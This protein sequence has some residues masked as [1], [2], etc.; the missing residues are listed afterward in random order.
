M[1]NIALL[2]AA[3]SHLYYAI[4]MSHPGATHTHV[5]PLDPYLA[6]LIAYVTMIGLT[7]RQGWRNAFALAVAVYAVVQLAALDTI[8]LSIV[9]TLLAGRAIGLAIPGTAR[10]RHRSRPTAR[11]PRT[12]LSFGG[13]AVTAIRRVSRS[14]T[15]RGGVPSTAQVTT[16]GMVSLDDVVFDRDQQA[17]GTFYRPVPPGSGCPGR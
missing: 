11:F 4:I 12:A 10:A 9:I 17:A 8:G 7:G 1:V 13:L 14:R 5:N 2:R 3:G 16:E 6:G 15:R